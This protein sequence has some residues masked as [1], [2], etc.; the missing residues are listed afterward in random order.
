MPFCVAS[1]RMTN[2]DGFS[3]KFSSDNAMKKITIGL[4]GEP[5]AG[6]DTVKDYLAEQYGAETLGFSLVLRD[7]LDR[8]ALVPSRANFAGL[9]EALRT[10]FGEAILTKVLVS[11]VEKL[12]ESIIVIDGIR[13][14]GELEELRT[15]P[16][17]HMVFVE[18]DLRVRYER[19]RHRGTKAD[20]LTKTFEEFVQDHEHAADRDVRNL[21]E[22]ADTVIENNGTVAELFTH[23]DTL[24]RS[25]SVDRNE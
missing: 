1:G 10:A 13:K 16:D 12:T 23:I 18:T 3:E 8:L 21:K 17:F 20:D 4:V 2:I 7:I 24:L 6:K 15:L 22:Y 5:G 19:I 25:L 14:R 11:D 9:A